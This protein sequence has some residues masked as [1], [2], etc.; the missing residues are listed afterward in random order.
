MDLK[1]LIEA[2]RKILTIAEKPEPQEYSLMLRVVISGLFLVG[3]VGLLIHLLFYFI[4]G[5]YGG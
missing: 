5:G 1:G 4:Q 2:W 3:I